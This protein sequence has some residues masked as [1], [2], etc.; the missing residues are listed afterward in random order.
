MGREVISMRKRILLIILSFLVLTACTSEYQVVQIPL[1]NA[2]VY[3]RSVT[4]G[5]VTL[6]VD[7]ISESERITTYFGVDLSKEKILPVN[8]IVTNHGKG[9]YVVKPS[10]IMLMKFNE[11][12]DPLSNETVVG[13]A[14]DLHARV[15]NKTERQV[16]AYFSNLALQ[17][18]M[19]GPNESRQG[20]LFFKIKQD[21]EDRNFIVRRL[22][23]EGTMKINAGVTNAETGERVHF[24]LFL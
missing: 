14:L 23:R 3:P 24:N 11:V 20:V 17:E 1:R 21:E 4:K 15:S 9:R 16:N 13:I 10:D 22:F 18:T 12:I 5:D 7:E 6:A 2:D 8:V 19:L